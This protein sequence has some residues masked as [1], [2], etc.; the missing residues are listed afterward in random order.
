MSHSIIT[1]VP[2]PFSADL[3]SVCPKMFLPS[4]MSICTFPDF[5]ASICQCRRF[6]SSS[7]RPSSHASLMSFRRSVDSGTCS[8]RP[9]RDRLLPS[10]ASSL[11]SSRSTVTR[12]RPLFFCSFVP[13]ALPPWRGYRADAAVD[14]CICAMILLDSRL[15]APAAPM[16]VTA[17]IICCIRDTLCLAIP[18]TPPPRVY[19][20]LLYHKSRSVA[21]QKNRAPGI[22][23]PCP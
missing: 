12:G 22:W 9:I 15:R 6:I 13:P 11:I 4:Q 19:A 10:A 16:P 8:A 17:V 21:R 1:V 2:P 3:P 20:F 14:S 5:A 7:A 23:A 18:Y